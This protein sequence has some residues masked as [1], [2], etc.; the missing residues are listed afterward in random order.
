[1]FM[2]GWNDAEDV[3]QFMSMFLAIIF[4]SSI[5]NISNNSCYVQVLENLKHPKRQMDKIVEN[6]FNEIDKLK[7]S[8][9]FS[10]SLY[11]KYINYHSEARGTRI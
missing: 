2:I 3:L 7:I 10:T 4:L 6:L 9:E 11:G 5:I 8:G 1:M